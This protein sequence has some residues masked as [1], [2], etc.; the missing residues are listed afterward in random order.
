MSESISV[1]GWPEDHGLPEREGH[2][3]NCPMEVPRE[4]RLSQE[5][6]LKGKVG[7]SE[8]PPMGKFADNP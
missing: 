5:A 3:K 6:Q 7:L 1:T 4:I 2:G 8:G